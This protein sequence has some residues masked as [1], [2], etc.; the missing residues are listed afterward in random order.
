MA[1]PRRALSLFLGYVVF[2][3]PSL[4]DRYRSHRQHFREHV[5]RALH[6]YLVKTNNFIN[7]VSKSSI[8]A[9]ALVPYMSPSPVGSLP[10]RLHGNRAAVSIDRVRALL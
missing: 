1:L 7:L 2:A 10:P 6:F 4:R 8:E 5:F 3:Y 9:I